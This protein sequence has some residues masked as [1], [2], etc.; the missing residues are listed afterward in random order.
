MINIE[1]A[2]EFHPIL[3]KDSKYKID[4]MLSTIRIFEIPIWIPFQNM[5]ESPWEES[6]VVPFPLAF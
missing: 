4:P 2:M 1:Y 3:E 6:R 5:G